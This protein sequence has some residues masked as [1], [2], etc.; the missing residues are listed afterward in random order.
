MW[1]MRHDAEGTCHD[2]I[3]QH[4]PVGDINTRA[5]VGDN[6]HRSPKHDSLPKM[7]ISLQRQMFQPNDVGHARRHGALLVGVTDELISIVVFRFPA[8][9]KE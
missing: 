1:S 7:N 6:D 8:A 2:C 9:L 3:L 5:L 4:S